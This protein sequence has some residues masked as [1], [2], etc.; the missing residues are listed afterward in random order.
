[1]RPFSLLSGWLQGAGGDAVA[2]VTKEVPIGVKDGANKLFQSNNPYINGTLQYWYNG[3]LMPPDCFTELGG[4]NFEVEI[5]PMAD[6]GHAIFYR[7]GF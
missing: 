7:T 5:P 2:I 1:M 6:D 4:V 3:S